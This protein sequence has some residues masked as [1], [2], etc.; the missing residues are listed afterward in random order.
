MG[1][2]LASAVF[3]VG[4]VVIWCTDLPPDSVARRLAGPIL[5]PARWLGLGH[6][7]KLFAPRPARGS[8]RLVLEVERADGGVDEVVYPPPSLL[9]RGRP[10][11]RALKLRRTLLARSN[12]GLRISFA[13]F[14]VRNDL[15][16]GAAAVAVRY[17]VE[18]RRSAPF[19]QP[20]RTPPP[21]KTS[22]PYTV[23]LD[24]G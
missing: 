8:T 3:V 15:E 11:G 21:V 4:A 12:P 19:A 22:R 2:V 9:V 16:P 18:R 17:R 23:P 10:I 5:R 20:D 24:P 7:W 13:R 1:E 14:V 6:T